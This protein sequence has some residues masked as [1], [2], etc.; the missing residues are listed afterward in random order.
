MAMN[1]KPNIT[2]MQYDT[3]KP[4]QFVFFQLNTAK[5]PDFI[6]FSSFSVHRI[7][8]NWYSWFVLG[9]HNVRFNPPS[10]QSFN[11][12][13]FLLNIFDVMHTDERTIN[14]A[15]VNN[16]IDIH[17][18]RAVIKFSIRSLRC[19]RVY[20]RN[21]RYTANGPCSPFDVV[22]RCDTARNYLMQ[23]EYTNDQSN[24]RSSLI[25]II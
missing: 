9:A 15:I 13:H 20:E 1:H 8:Y 3:V 7:I 11:L 12:I 25:P 24:H 23:S 4:T 10:K 16:S 14:L 6:Y 19:R 2:E 22:V 5:T 21:A 18:T 17:A